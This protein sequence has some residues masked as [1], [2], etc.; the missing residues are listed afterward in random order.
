MQPRVVSFLPTLFFFTSLRC[1]EL[2]FA[3]NRL[4]GP[5]VRKEKKIMNCDRFVFPGWRERK[6]KN[7]NVDDFFITP[8]K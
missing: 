5:G 4:V 8:A 3:I 7:T 2:L 1:D 6:K